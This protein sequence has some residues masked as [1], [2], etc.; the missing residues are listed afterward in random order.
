MDSRPTRAY[1]TPHGAPGMGAASKVRWA[2]L[3]LAGGVALRVT[4]RFE[5]F[6]ASLVTH[7][8]ESPRVGSLERDE[9]EALVELLAAFTASRRSCWFG[10]WEGYG[11]MQGPPAIAEAV[12][13]LPEDGP[14]A[15]RK[16]LERAGP[17]G[18]RVEIPERS[19]ALYSGPIEAAAA[20]LG[21]PAVQS[22]N[23]W[24]QEDHAWCVASEI[25]FRSTYLGGAQALIDR[26]LHD[27]RLEA[28]P[29][30][31]ADRVTD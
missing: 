24:W 3:A 18:P 16:A 27:K 17:A 6:E 10:V 30:R 11:W 23:L 9:L 12:A 26:V 13:L 21:P 31:L 5:E 1:F 22:P 2:E 28:I 4:T 20:F 19:L 8:T 7:G 25:D 14:P 15:R 29:A